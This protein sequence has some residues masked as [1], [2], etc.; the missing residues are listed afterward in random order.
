MRTTTEVATPAA[1]M[2][3]T[4]A[5][6]NPR[7]A[8]TTVPPA[9]ITAWPAV[10]TARPT[11][12]STLHASGQV[13]AMTGHQEQRVVDTDAEP[14]HAGH[15][16]RPARDVDDVGDERHRADA[17]GQAE[18]RHADGKTHRDER[19]ERNQ[20]DDGGKEHTCHLAESRLCFFELQEQLTSHL[21]LQ[22]RISSGLSDEFLEVL[23]IADIELARRPGTGAGRSR[24]CRPATT[25]PDGD[26]RVRRQPPTPQQGRS[27]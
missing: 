1:V 14:D 19:T 25:E 27:C 9:K 26:R 6:A 23:Q 21:D 24:H 3:G 10:A 7:M 20:Q 11:D 4:P 13:L 15:L 12:S 17:D 5:S 18:Q 16:R 22:R 8:M 2:N